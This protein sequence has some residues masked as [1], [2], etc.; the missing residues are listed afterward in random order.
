MKTHTTSQILIAPTFL[1]TTIER[2][3]GKKKQTLADI[4][5]Q[6]NLCSQNET[7]SSLW[8]IRK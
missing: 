2:D 7:G 6:Q 8:S 5:T 1:L 3:D 4:T